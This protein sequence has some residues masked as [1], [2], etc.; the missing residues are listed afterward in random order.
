MNKEM[1]L[2]D[3][4]ICS[5]MPIQESKILQA[6]R[7]NGDN[8][9]QRELLRITENLRFRNFVLTLSHSNYLTALGGTEKLIHEE[10]K[11]LAKHGI[12]YI[13]VYSAE[14]NDDPSVKAYPDRFVG[15]N[16][17]SIPVGTFTIIQFG[18][19]LQILNLSRIA[20]PF[21]VHIHHLMR[22]PIWGVN[23]LVNA[24]SP[25]KLRV[26]IHDYYTVCPQ[27]NLLRN[28]KT[29]CGAPPADG[30]GCA[31]CEWHSR[32]IPHFSEIQKLFNR[33]TPDPEFIFPSQVAA[34]IWQV[35]H[36]RQK[37][38]RVIPHQIIRETRADN[39]ERLKRLND[40]EYRPSIAYLGYESFN[41]GLETWWRLT[42]E[43][44]FEDHYIFRHLG[45]SGMNLPNVSYIPVSFLEDGP[46]A[47]I[48]SL[49]K[50]ETD[51][52]FLWSVCPE[53]YSFTLHEALAANCFVVTN[54][55]SGNIAAQIQGTGRG[56][57]FDN[58]AEMFDFFKDSK[59]VKDAV[60]ACLR[61]NLPFDL[62]FNPQL[63]FEL[64]DMKEDA[65]LDKSPADIFS[66]EW[67]DIM[68]KLELESMRAAYIKRSEATL[69]TATER[70]KE[71]SFQL[72][73]YH[74]SKP[75]RIV[76][77]IRQYADRH[78]LVGSAMRNAFLKLW[79]M[80]NG[81]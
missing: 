4:K 17:D 41:K 66:P 70:N 18:L 10:Q 67:E 62:E 14:P 79:N 6:F 2:A 57:I 74:T 5:E 9:P 16:V 72:T 43:K 23:Y 8:L 76:E 69:D 22:L 63:T 45:S 7:D 51:I 36:P 28:G 60:A 44:Q 19:I 13:Q 26:F 56:M 52:A 47:M 46:D 39:T 31:E 20:N 49:R 75:H 15:V 40:P 21:A 53:T 25:R 78:P 3:H 64:S 81:Q 58:E 59:R 42:S 50:H 30:E 11:E 33:L 71:L 54:P 24:V 73:H 48:R 55:F 38:V 37:S 12:S 35:S 27:F 80:V 65:R 68:A 77:H 61:G 34:D 1:S 32:R 29:Y